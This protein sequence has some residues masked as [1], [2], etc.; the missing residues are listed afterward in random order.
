MHLYLSIH[1]IH[2]FNKCI[3]GPLTVSCLV[4]VAAERENSDKSHADPELS[5]SWGDRD[6]GAL[7]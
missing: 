7:G 5:L 6:A 3:F 4:L 1:K 2:S